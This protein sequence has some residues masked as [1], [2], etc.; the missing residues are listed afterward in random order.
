MSQ[1]GP[2]S[3]AHS[4]LGMA[5][6]TWL[7]ELIVHKFDQIFMLIILELLKWA[8]RSWGAQIKPR[9]LTFEICTPR[10]RCTPEHSIQI[11]TPRFKEAQSGSGEPQSAHLSFLGTLFNAS[12][13]FSLFYTILWLLQ[14]SCCPHQ[15]PRRKVFLKPYV[16]YLPFDQNQRNFQ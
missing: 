6:E 15:I 13:G 7:R 16:V 2:F 10:L 12:T 1:L 9:K 3:V 5:E 11:S 14:T 8:W 4:L